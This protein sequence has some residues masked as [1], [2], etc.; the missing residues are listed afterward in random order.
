VGRVDYTGGAD[1]YRRA[2]TLPDE[3]LA[4]WRRTLDRAALPRPDR[5]LDVGAG[6]GGFLGPL[7]R[8]FGA[9]VVAVEPSN[10]MRSEA[11]AAGLARRYPYVAAY[12]ESLPLASGSI[13]LA[14]LS[15][16]IH[17]VD[18]RDQA[19]RELRRVVAGDGRVLLRGFFSDMTITGLFAA[20]PGIERSARS[21]PSTDEVRSSFEKAGFSTEHVED[22]IEPW[23][24]ELTAWTDRVQSVRHIDSALR[25][26]DDAEF[27]EGL[28][29]VLE[30]HRDSR[31][32][33]ASDS[34]LRLIILG[35]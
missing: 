25:P 27:A 4:S 15:T 14:W 24:F 33:I 9:A 2:R 31:D 29:V 12:A 30:T 23:R 8:W 3:V 10:A 28:R 34:T 35:A 19:A 6:T 20:F 26:L 1:A 16:V 18:D 5:V 11:K 7:E 13:D 32:P 21:F 17:Q 22:V